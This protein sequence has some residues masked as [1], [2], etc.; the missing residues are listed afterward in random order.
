[1]ADTDPTDATRVR[2]PGTSI[3]KGRI[4]RFREG[5]VQV[6]EPWPLPAAWTKRDGKPWRAL[7]PWVDLSAVS[8][9]HRP[10]SWTSVAEL[11]A[12]EQVPQDI[13][14]A[15]VDAHLDRLQWASLQFAARVPGGLHLLRDVPLLG[16]ALS[17]A[18]TLRPVPV[19]R[20]LRSARALLRRGRGK[21]TWRRVAAWLGF[22]GS[23]A[24][25]NTLR[26]VKLEPSRPWS[27]E[28]FEGIRAA[29]RQPRAK[30]LLL[31][32]GQ[33]DLDSVQLIVTAME[34]GVID[35]L[36]P[37]VVAAAF[38]AGLETTVPRR[39]GEVAGAWPTVHPGRPLP[40]VKSAEA[41]DALRERLRHEI[42]AKFAVP[43]IEIPEAF[44]P[45][46]LPP[47]PGVRALST[48]AELRE[49]AV[50]MS[51]CL[52]LDH[53]DEWTRMR[54]GYAYSVTVNPHNRADVWIAPD[55][56]RPGCFEV[57][58][59]RG[60]SNEPPS[61][62]CKRLVELWIEQHRRLVASAVSA[63]QL[64]PAPWRSAWLPRPVSQ[65]PAEVSWAVD[66]MPF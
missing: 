2:T 8:Q 18:Y 38:N 24:F 30:K 52:H 57:Q 66:E 59:V 58:E 31:H 43:T 40:V 14:Q 17:C 60:P 9:H 23:Q 11:E 48:A 35:H 46:P 41:L 54:L 64:V 29:W 7:R 36:H 63:V 10:F 55:P 33:L 21:K 4:Y 27:V 42:E 13:A 61:E 1:M 28:L 47:L 49:E 32:A 51:N 3:H 39:F 15:V 50:A 44:P 5:S 16:A 45:P 34:L 6:I 37:A 20:P 62:P 12:L 19:Q 56:N 65:L 22:E 53:W 26:R 25:V